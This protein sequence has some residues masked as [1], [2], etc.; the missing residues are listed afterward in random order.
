[1]HHFGCDFAL[2]VDFRRGTKHAYYYY[3]QNPHT[4]FFIVT[5]FFYHSEKTTKTTTYERRHCFESNFV[6]TLWRLYIIKNIRF[7]RYI[8]YHFSNNIRQL[9]FYYHTLICIKHCFLSQ[10]LVSFIYRFVLYV[11]RK[12]V[13]RACH[14]ERLVSIQCYRLFRAQAHGLVTG[15][16]TALK[17]VV[18]NFSMC[19]C[20]FL[21]T[22]I[23]S[24]SSI[25]VSIMALDYSGIWITTK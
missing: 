7:F 22:L 21:I 20:S 3:R 10:Q 13:L 15:P 11:I 16:R 4:T 23:I 12:N 5:I 1:M 6:F 19:W 14:V 9:V 8:W 2:N 17:H 18:W 25:P 24:F